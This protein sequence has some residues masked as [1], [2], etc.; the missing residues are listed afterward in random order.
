MKKKTDEPIK[1]G[2]CRSIALA[3]TFSQLH[4]HACRPE[5]ASTEVAR[6]NY[7]TGIFRF[8]VWRRKV[9]LSLMLSDRA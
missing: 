4:V 1:K 3:R 6:V 7:P 5:L 2:N 8:G 9:K